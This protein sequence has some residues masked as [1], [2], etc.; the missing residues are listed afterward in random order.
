MKVSQLKFTHKSQGK[1]WLV[2]NDKSADRPP[3]FSLLNIYIYV[4][5]H[6]H[7]HTHTHTYTLSRI[8]F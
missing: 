1:R 7:T 5:I 2:A 3:G 4:Y 6:I 8:L